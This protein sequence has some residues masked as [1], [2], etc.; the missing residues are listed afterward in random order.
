MLGIIF[1]S[2]EFVQFICSA[3]VSL[4]CW[5]LQLIILVYRFIPANEGLIYQFQYLK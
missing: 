4:E 2:P 1:F 5:F 3:F